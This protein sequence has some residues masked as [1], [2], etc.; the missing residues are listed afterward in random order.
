MVLSN[1]QRENMGKKADQFEDSGNEFLETFLNKTNNNK[2][3][4]DQE[5]EA[6]KY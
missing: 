4:D 6:Q 1:K 2:N 3:P 5:Y